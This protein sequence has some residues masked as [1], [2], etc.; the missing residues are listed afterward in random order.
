M[1]S[2]QAE[3]GGQCVLQ[4]VLPPGKRQQCGIQHH[5]NVDPHCSGGRF[6]CL[7]RALLTL[8][9]GNVRMSQ[10]GTAFCLKMQVWHWQR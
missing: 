2:S 10:S 6:D 7:C 8:E 5:L 3:Y 1:E 4:V 9:H